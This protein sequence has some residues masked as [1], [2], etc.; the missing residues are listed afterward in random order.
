MFTYYPQTTGFYNL[1]VFLGEHERE[2][3]Y[4]KI[5]INTCKCKLLGKVNQAIK[6]NLCKFN[7][8]VLKRMF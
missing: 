6:K 8:G 3:H 1:R 4:D 5:V 7:L 2:G